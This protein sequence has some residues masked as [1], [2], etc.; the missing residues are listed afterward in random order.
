[1][2]SDCDAADRGDDSNESNR[3]VRGK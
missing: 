1:M 2:Y 3:D